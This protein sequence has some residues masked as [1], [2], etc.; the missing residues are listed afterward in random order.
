M[1]KSG[2]VS[3]LSLFENLWSVPKAYETNENEKA[4]LSSMTPVSSINNENSPLN[5]TATEKR[6]AK[7]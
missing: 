1:E 7:R 2:K 3:A 5:P 4:C 6:H